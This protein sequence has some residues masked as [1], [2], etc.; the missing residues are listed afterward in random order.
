MGDLKSVPCYAVA[1]RQII[2]TKRI[3][4]LL[5]CILCFLL[6]PVWCFCWV[7]FV[8]DLIQWTAVI[9]FSVLLL[10]FWVFTGSFLLSRVLLTVMLKL[11]CV[12]WPAIVQGNHWHISWCSVLS[13]CF[14]HW[15]IECWCLYICS[16]KSADWIFLLLNLQLISFADILL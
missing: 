16:I 12:C 9:V 10:I 1:M 11:F 6:Y 8:V 14:P 13:N 4:L 15:F 3:W 7:N 2:I 5:S